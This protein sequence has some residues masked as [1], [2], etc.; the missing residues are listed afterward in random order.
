M[1]IGAVN[2]GVL[3]MIKISPREQIELAN[4]YNLPYVPK[5]RR[6]VEGAFKRAQ[7]DVS[8]NRTTDAGVEQAI[9]RVGGYES[10][11]LDV[12]GV[13]DDEIEKLLKDT[14]L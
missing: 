2:Y 3:I 10:I 1:S 8:Y 5:T 7:R 4:K 12:F 9:L 11:L 14:I 13:T 6:G